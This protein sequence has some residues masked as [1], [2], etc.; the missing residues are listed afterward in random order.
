MIIASYEVYYWLKFAK[1]IDLDTYKIIPS[2][3]VGFFYNLSN[4]EGIN[5]IIYTSMQLPI[6]ITLPVFNLLVI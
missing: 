3:L 5:I 2:R 1:F 6:F 4:W